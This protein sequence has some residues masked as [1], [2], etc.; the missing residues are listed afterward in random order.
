MG[1]TIE[2]IAVSSDWMRLDSSTWNSGLYFVVLES[3]DQ[4]QVKLWLKN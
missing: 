3:R 2:K 1:R 4:R